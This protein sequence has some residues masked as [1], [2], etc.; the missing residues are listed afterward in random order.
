MKFGLHRLPFVGIR[1]RR[2]ALDDRFPQLGELRV[3]RLEPLLVG[4]H[5]VFGKDRLHGTFG[6]TQGAVDAFIRVDDQKI[7][8]FTEAVDR[9]DVDAIGVFATN[10]ALGYY[11]SQSTLYSGT[12]Y[13]GDF[14]KFTPTLVMQGLAQ[15]PQMPVVSL[16]NAAGLAVRSLADAI[17]FG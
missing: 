7:G 9:T 15:P 14:S 1:R 13:S 11:V 3:E 5:I 17:P 6:D 2:L 16:L 4:R 8:P 10:A 12:R